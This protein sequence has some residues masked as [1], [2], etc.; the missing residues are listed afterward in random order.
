MK[1]NRPNQTESPMSKVYKNLLR[2]FSDDILDLMQD[3]IFISDR[4]GTTLR[5]NKAYEELTG[6]SNA[7]VCGK[8][9]SMLQDDGIFDVVLNPEIVKTKKP[10]SK[11]QK[12][13]RN[14]KVVHLQGYPIFDEKGEVCLVVTFARDVTVMTKL[15]EVMAEQR[16]TIEKYEGRIADIAGLQ[17][18]TEGIFASPVMRELVDMLLRIAQT[19]ATVLLLGETGAGKDVLA[20]MVHHASP[21]KDKMFMK[22]DCSSIAENLIESELFGYAKGA[23]S[24]ASTQGRAGYFEIADG[25]T[26]FLD[27]IGELPLPMQ[28]KLLRVLQDQEI[29]RVGSSHV[30]KVDVRIVAATN[31]DLTAEIAEGKFRQDLYYRLNVARMNVPPLRERLEDIPLLANYFLEIHSAKYKKQM[32]LTKAAMDS[33]M[34]YAWPGNVRELYNVI[35]QLVV[36]KPNGTVDLNDMPLRMRESVAANNG[37]VHSVETILP[38]LETA[39]PL[40]EIMADLEKQIIEKALQKYGSVNKVSAIFGVNRSTLFRKLHR[41][42]K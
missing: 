28:S 12:L 38:D 33:L 17:H 20:R 18:I 32:H 35:L 21:R 2:E 6:L 13:G 8:P 29:M 3:G 14:D 23:F 42:S 1:S 22:V 27:E 11:V 16:H 10:T 7:E 37:I 9:V 19:D 41:K 25:G 36:T 24:G 4:Q 5:I 34:A 30:T 31:R 40:S 15:R 39:R 26:V